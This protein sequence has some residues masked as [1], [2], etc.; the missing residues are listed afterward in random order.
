[1]RSAS[2]AAQQIARA[3]MGPWDYATNGTVQILLENAYR[4]TLT[5]DA[6]YVRVDQTYTAVFDMDM[7]AIP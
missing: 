7:S 4:P 2:D 1:V 5:T 3:L 6:Q